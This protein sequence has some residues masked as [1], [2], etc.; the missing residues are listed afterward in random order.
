MTEL[1]IELTHW[2]LVTSYDIAELVIIDSGNG[3]S[4]GWHQAFTWTNSDLSI[5][6]PGT[7]IREIWIKRN[8]VHSG[9]CI[10][11]MS[12]AKWQPFCSSLNELNITMLSRVTR[13][14]EEGIILS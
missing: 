9:K 13:A 12:S 2:G 6:P 1:I 3:L 14:G 8:H 10:E 7:N 4:P 11:K 5:R